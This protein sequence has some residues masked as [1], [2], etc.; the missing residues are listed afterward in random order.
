MTAAAQKLDPESSGSSD[1]AGDQELVTYELTEAS[2]AQAFAKK[3]E[4]DLRFIPATGAWLR[5]VYFAHGWRP[6]ELNEVPDLCRQFMQEFGAGKPGLQRKSAVMGVLGMASGIPPIPVK[7]GEFDRKPDLLGT[8]EGTV[9]LRS[10]LMRKGVRTDF[11][12]KHTLCG[13]SDAGAEPKRF[14][15]FLDEL[16]GGDE[17]MISFLQV[18]SGYCL[19]GHVNEHKFLWLRGVG[20]A[21]T[22]T[23]VNLVLA[24]M[25]DYGA[26]LS[27]GLL[28]ESSGERHLAELSPLDGARAVWSPEQDDGK[29]WNEPLILIIVSGD[30]LVIRMMR[31]NPYQIRSTAKLMITSNGYPSVRGVRGGM[32]RR[33]LLADFKIAAKD[34]DRWLLDKLLDER[35]EIL[36]WAIDGAVRWYQEG[37]VVPKTVLDASAQYLEDEDTFALW[38]AECC[39]VEPG[40]TAR[41]GELF[42]SWKEWCQRRNESPGTSKS[43]SHQLT[44]RNFEKHKNLPGMHGVRGYSGLQLRSAPRGWE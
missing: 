26:A 8:P 12:S 44:S 38:L 10:G 15:T 25:R 34:K 16:T 27:P 35:R 17:S 24:L 41:A 1:S 28:Q 32:R 29:R 20:G 31:G 9:E 43:F 30:P 3:Y 18:W 11:I 13:P 14:L 5:W 33:L 40:L 19:T 6:Q 2:A 39:D 4:E 22:S 23:F 21:G 42:D 7:P 36:R 37:L